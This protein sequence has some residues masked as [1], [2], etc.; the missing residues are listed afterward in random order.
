MGC[1]EMA[2]QVLFFRA[3]RSLKRQLSKQGFGKRWLL[4]ALGLFARITTPAKASP[5]SI[6]V[7]SASTRVGL[8]TTVIGTMGTKLGIAAVTAVTTA[9]IIVGGVT[10]LS[11]TSTHVSPSPSSDVSSDLVLSRS[12]FEY[13]RLLLDAYDPDGDGWQ[14][15]KRYG[16]DPVR[17]SPG[18]WLV[19]PPPSNLSSVILPVAHWVE[20]KF[21]GKIVDGPGNDIFLIEWGASGEQVRVFITD[22]AGN[23]Y[24]LGIGM[25]GTSGQR[26]A[27]EIG[28]DI[29]G[30]SLPFVP[31][32]VR[33]LGIRGGGETPGFDLHSVR[34]RTYISQDD[35]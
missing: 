26:V 16:L 11:N 8:I 35:F 7:T 5:V 25:T 31:C 27:T 6:T 22:G 34:T 3:K 19:G 9:T 32:A 14:G 18:Q 30:I 28:F 24:L 23:E 1:S 10:S 13:P 15:V 21:H 20:L 12:T 29:S 2:A 33:I 4:M 17:I